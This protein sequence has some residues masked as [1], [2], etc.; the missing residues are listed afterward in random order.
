M[1][2]S[3][4]SPARKNQSGQTTSQPTGQ[5]TSQSGKTSGPDMALE[6]MKAI[7]RCALANIAV[8]IGLVSDLVEENIGDL[9]E[10]FI[11]LVKYSRQQVEDIA[12]ACNLLPEGDIVRNI[13]TEI[14]AVS[15][16]F[17][18]NVNR[19]IYSLQFQDRSRQLMQAMVATL[20][21]LIGLSE[22]LENNQV[23]EILAAKPV[24]SEESRTILNHLIADADHQELD[25]N[26]I[27]KMFMGEQKAETAGEKSPDSANIDFF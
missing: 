17:D 16:G 11:K 7:R 18:I 23:G 5:T 27:V 20:D 14:M 3:S 22:S 10:E 21:I 25:R 15:T 12:M 26:Y 24:I 4:L 9:S 19:M 8:E 2:V 13:L 1:I 6:D